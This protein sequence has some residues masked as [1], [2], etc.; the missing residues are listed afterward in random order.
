MQTVLLCGVGET[1]QVVTETLYALLVH[2]Q[3]VP[4]EVHVLTT[5]V[6]R[7]RVLDGLLHRSEGQYY[8]FCRDYGLDHRDILFGNAQVHVINA[9]AGGLED[10]RTVTENAV[11][12]RWLSEFVR[13]QAKRSDVQL[14]A[15]L[16]GGRKTM[17][18][19]LGHAMQMYGRRRDRLTHVL[20]SEDFETH[21]AFF[22]PP[23]DAATLQTRSGKQIRTSD[24]EVTLV[25]VPFLRLR[26]SLNLEA[27][28]GDFAQTVA[29]A[30]QQL[31]RAPSLRIDVADGAVQVGDAVCR[32]GQAPQLFALY[33]H[34]LF[35]RLLAKADSEIGHFRPAADTGDAA[36]DANLSAMDTEHRAEMWE[37]AAK[38]L[39]CGDALDVWRNQ[40]DADSFNPYLNGF[41][42]AFASKVKKLNDRLKGALPSPTVERWLK[43]DRCG[44]HPVRYGVRLPPDCIHIGPEGG[45]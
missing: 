33:L 17:S 8:R 5:E 3:T 2:E 35:E 7:R 9:A 1:P 40:L 10:L 21:P 36:G 38:R 4:A 16:A 13:E 14:H 45:K 37:A 27:I 28:E 25:E 18:Y 32:L 20:V 44:R 19:Y 34:F 11:A 43:V 12:G 26:E 39:Q 42:T 41:A 23:K 22:F 6:G 30:Q 15:S 31:D 24:A 29:A